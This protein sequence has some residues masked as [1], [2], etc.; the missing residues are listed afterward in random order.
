M[1]DPIKF[2]FI[3][4]KYGHYASWAIWAEEGDKSK[5]NMGD[6]T[7]FDR[8]NYPNL[9]QQLKPEII[10]VGLNISRRIEKP[11]ANFHGSNRDAYKIKY[12]LNNSPFWGAYMGEHT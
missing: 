9:F 8:G 5:S 2:E 12:A 6:L 4:E 1:I 7:I 11:L 10:L 3:K